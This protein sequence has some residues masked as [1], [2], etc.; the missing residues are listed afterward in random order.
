MSSN[1]AGSERYP[2]NLNVSFWD[3]ETLAYRQTIMIENPIRIHLSDDGL[4]FFA[5]VGKGKTSN[6]TNND[7]FVRIW[8]TSTGEIEKTICF[9]FGWSVSFALAV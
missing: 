6:G 5:A 9:R 2:S 4:R 3:G 7:A 1:A 8:K